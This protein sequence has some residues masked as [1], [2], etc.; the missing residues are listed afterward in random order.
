MYT[1]LIVT[2]YV[3][4]SGC[5]WIQMMARWRGDEPKRIVAVRTLLQV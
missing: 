3:C 2:M 4:M 1:K 5:V